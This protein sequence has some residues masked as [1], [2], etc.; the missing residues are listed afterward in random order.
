MSETARLRH[1]P[2]FE[3][4][5]QLIAARGLDPKRLL[6]FFCEHAGGPD[7]LLRLALP[8]GTTVEAVVRK[9]LTTKRY[10]SIIEWKTLSAN[11][12]D[13]EDRL[14]Q[15]IVT[16]DDVAAAFSRAAE[17]YYEFRRLCGGDSS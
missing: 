9:D 6:L 4:V 3:D 12:A 11:P 2:R 1:S 10:T 5:R 16:S 8:G 13:E 14:A 7:M 17:R 15:H